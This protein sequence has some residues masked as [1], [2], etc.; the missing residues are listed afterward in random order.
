MSAVNA[1]FANDAPQ[2]SLQEVHTNGFL[3]VFCEGAFAVPLY[4]GALANCSV[5]NHN[6]FY[7]YFYVLLDHSKG[8]N[9]A[10]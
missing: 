1:I 8:S 9:A 4:E 5:S 2:L 6:N 3:V 7:G 10:R